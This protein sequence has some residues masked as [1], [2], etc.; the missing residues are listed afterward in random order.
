M[1]KSVE[2]C[3]GYLDRGRF[4]AT[5]DVLDDIPLQQRTRRFLV[6]SG[7]PRD[8][9]TNVAP[10]DSL[11]LLYK[12]GLV[13]HP[14]PV[15]SIGKANK[16]WED[17]LWFLDDLYAI[18]QYDFYDRPDSSWPT[19]FICI[20]TARNDVLVNVDLNPAYKEDVAISYLNRDVEC[21]VRSLAEFKEFW[22]YMDPHVQAWNDEIDQPDERGFEEVV[23]GVIEESKWR[24]LSIDPTGF[25]CSYL[26]STGLLVKY[27]W[28][29]MY[30]AWSDPN[31]Y[32]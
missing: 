6:E 1:L 31:F 20:D 22:E 19:Q 11:T 2:A 7:L 3:I 23:L 26:E 4:K 29:E 5:A 25:G 17:R 21:Y 27:H 32:L 12:F 15:R 30:E 28:K 13:E 18:G 8:D 14:V 24:W 9:L 10:L 16:A